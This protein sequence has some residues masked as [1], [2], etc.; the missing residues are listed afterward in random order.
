ML[1]VP[2]YFSTRPRPRVHLFICVKRRFFIIIAMVEIFLLNQRLVAVL[3]CDETLIVPWV[4]DALVE[5]GEVIDA[6]LLAT[7]VFLVLA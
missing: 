7:E 4:D 2:A 5:V 1:T 6:E 3:Y